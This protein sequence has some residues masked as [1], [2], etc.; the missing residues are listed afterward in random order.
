M[1]P[2]VSFIIIFIIIISYLILYHEIQTTHILEVMHAAFTRQ[3]IFEIIPFI[4][5]FTTREMKFI[6]ISTTSNF[7][8]SIIGRT[9][10]GMIA[11]TFVTFSLI[12]PPTPNNSKPVETV[13]DPSQ[14]LKLN[15]F[16][17][18]VNLSK[19]KKDDIIAY[20]KYIT[21]ATI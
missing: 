12:S 9:L 17:S 5:L 16:T 19:N 6:D 15:S 10:I 7:F 14:L 1:H 20:E 18:D 13:T 8:N 11:F 2:L 3:F 21:Y 4:I